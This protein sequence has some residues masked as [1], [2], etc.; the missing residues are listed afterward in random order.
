MRQFSWLHRAVAAVAAMA[1]SWVGAP[2]WRAVPEWER[3]V[4]SA[5]V[6]AIGMV[7]VAIGMVVAAI[8]MVVVI[9]MAVAIGM[10]A[11]IM[12]MMLSS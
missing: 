7:A 2:E 8:G 1:I 5:G 9:G 11:T 3:G 6:V 4:V 12:A 10:A